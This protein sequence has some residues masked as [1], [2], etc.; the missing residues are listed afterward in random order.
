M[1]GRIGAHVTL[2]HDVADHAIA[3]DRLAVA[4]S[5]M[6]PIELGL[7]E[8]A[9]WG[10]ARWGIY[11]GVDDQA[12]RVQALHDELAS[13]EDPRWLRH[14]FRPHVTVVHGRYVDA[15][16]ADEAW[17]ALRGW[18]PRQRVTIDRVSVIEMSD[19]GWQTV[20]E[21]PLAASPE[22]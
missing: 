22:R 1:A 11:L 9:T 19:A 12:G 13:V 14:G 5:A 15:D 10:P 17:R 4:A 20:A 18:A 21:H 2:V 8:T 16:T 6:A 7:T 3:H